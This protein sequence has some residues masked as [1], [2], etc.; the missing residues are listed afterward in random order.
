MNVSIDSIL[1][2]SREEIDNCG[3]ANFSI[4]KVA[5]TLNV[6]KGAIYKIFK[7]KEEVIAAIIIEGNRVRNNASIDILDD[8]ELNSYEKILCHHLLGIYKTIINK[9]DIGTI[10]IVANGMLWNSISTSI[11]DDI[12]REFLAYYHFIDKPHLKEVTSS[13]TQSELNDIKQVLFE[14][15]RG[16]L[17]GCL[18]IFIPR[19]INTF[20]RVDERLH[21][22]VADCFNIDK[23][24]IDL[25][26]VKRWV[27][28]F[29]NSPPSWAKMYS[30]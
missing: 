30:L 29:L 5:K 2:A 19:K 13:L 28:I 6:P 27:D 14:T 16:V 10:F 21:H 15:E 1:W 24:K 26:K 18:N 22:V 23:N 12:Q 20:E 7:N 17:L 11:L 3:L 8:N 9:H 25:S 4:S